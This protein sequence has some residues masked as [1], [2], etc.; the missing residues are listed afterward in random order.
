LSYSLHLHMYM[1]RGF[2]NLDE[3]VVSMGLA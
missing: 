2:F 3:I 1:I